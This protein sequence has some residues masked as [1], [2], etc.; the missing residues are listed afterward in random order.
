MNEIVFNELNVGYKVLRFIAKKSSE[1][2]LRNIFQKSVNIDAKRKSIT[3][4]LNFIK[5]KKFYGVSV[6]PT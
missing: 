2:Q 3:I 1:L 4:D 6:K 5:E